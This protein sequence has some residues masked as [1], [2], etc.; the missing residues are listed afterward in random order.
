MISRGF[1]CLAAPLAIVI[2][3]HT[4]S[5]GDNAQARSLKASIAFTD[6][7][8]SLTD[9]STAPK[10]FKKAYYKYVESQQ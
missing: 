1:G 3:Q 6:N 5:L 10:P 2:L 8:G 4:G 9:I 7:S